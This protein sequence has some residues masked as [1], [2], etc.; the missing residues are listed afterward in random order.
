MIHNT[1][2]LFKDLELGEKIKLAD[3]RQ[4]IKD[5]TAYDNL[6]V[7]EEDRMKKDLLEL[8]VQRKIGAR[9]SNKSAAQDYRAQM[10]N[11]N[12]EVC[13]H[14]S[15]LSLSLTLL[16]IILFRYLHCRKE[17]ALRWSLSLVAPAL[18]TPLSR[19]G[20]V[21]RMQQTSLRRQ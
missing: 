12:S 11:M 9:P 18:K 17:L 13:F 21:H 20:F 5:D 6:T 10:T 16:L 8:R 7:E 19:T 2:N 1:Y 14:S 4:L 15:F 3:L